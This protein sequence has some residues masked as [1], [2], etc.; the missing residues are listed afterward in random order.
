MLLRRRCMERPGFSSRLDSPSRGAEMTNARF[1]LER[2]KTG[3]ARAGVPSNRQ[4]FRRLVPQAARAD[5]QRWRGGAGQPKYVSAPIVLACQRF[6]LR[7]G[8]GCHRSK[9]VAIP[10]FRPTLIRWNATGGTHFSTYMKVVWRQGHS[11]S[12]KTRAN[13]EMSTFRPGEVRLDAGSIVTHPGLHS[14]GAG[15]GLIFLFP[16]RVKLVGTAS[17]GQ[18]TGDPR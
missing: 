15:K 2:A 14:A 5:G 3:P 11:S 16:A 17:L 18:T 12:A 8:I 7:R 6:V 13:G 1:L 4:V 9:V 10:A